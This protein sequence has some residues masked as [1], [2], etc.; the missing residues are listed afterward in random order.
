MT[1][2][3]G[4]VA[5]AAL[6]L[7]PS[8][9]RTEEAGKRMIHHLEVTVRSCRAE[10]RLNGFPLGNVEARSDAPASFEPPVN[11]YLAGAR[12]VV[13][14]VLDASTGFDGKVLPLARATLELT[15]RRFGVGEVVEPGAGELV[16]RFVL[17]PGQLAELPAGKRKPPITL[18]HRF[19]NSAPDF[20]AELLDEKP[21]TDEKALREYAM[22][23]RALVV[24]RDVAGLLA[25]FEPKLRVWGTAYAAPHA[26]MEESLRGALVELVGEGVDVAFGRED[27]EPR[28]WCGGRIWEL[29]RRGGVPL[30]R[31]VGGPDGALTELPVYVA[32]RGG[33]L[34]VVR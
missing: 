8:A 20:S 3:L 33:V 32:L 16:T 14:V 9:G 28:A 12:N 11:P 13:E 25:E 4:A 18:T 7:V 10:V 15:V 1:N 27:V 19:A 5:G 24:N 26:D 21:F 17:A 23:L 30:L 34:R 2:A 31:R 29:A 6:L 22:K